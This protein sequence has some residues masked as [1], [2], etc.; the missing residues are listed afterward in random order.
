MLSQLLTKTALKKST[1]RLFCY[2]LLSESEL[3]VFDTIV[4][5][6]YKCPHQLDCDITDHHRNII[7][8]HCDQIPS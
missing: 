7:Y 5:R 2:L 4:T 3:I 6:A 1:E 8:L